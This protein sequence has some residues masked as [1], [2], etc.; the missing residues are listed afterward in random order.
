LLGDGGKQVPAEMYTH[1]IT[2]LP[3]LGNGEVNTPLY[4]DELLGNGVF[5]AVRTEI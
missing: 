5:Y 4:Q 1:A 2:E 3:F